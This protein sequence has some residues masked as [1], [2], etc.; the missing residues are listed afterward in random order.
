MDSFN[1][2]VTKI[3][4][5]VWGPVML[6]LLVGTGIFLTVR[7]R[8]LTWRNLGYALKST[9]S[10]EARHQEPRTGRCITFFRTDNRTG[11]HHRYRNYRRCC[12]S[13]GFRWSRSSGLELLRYHQRTD[14]YPEP[15]LH[16]PVKRRDCQR[17]KRIQAGD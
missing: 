17:C 5:F 10:K 7:T 4:D 13:H 3:D 8:F 9:L 15:D 2:N 6:I 14:G 1:E 12:H 16:A 11:S